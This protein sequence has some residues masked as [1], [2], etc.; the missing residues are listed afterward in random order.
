MYEIPYFSTLPKR[1]K[2]PLSSSFNEISDNKTS[3]ANS[4]NSDLKALDFEI[5]ENDDN[6]LDTYNTDSSV[7]PF[8]TSVDL[9]STNGFSTQKQEIAINNANDD[10]LQPDKSNEISPRTLISGYQFLLGRKV[11]KNIIQ[12]GTLL[13]PRDKTIDVD[14]V[15]L[16]RKFGKLVELTVSSIE[17]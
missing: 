13:I 4:T 11:V 1:A 8:A 9:T 7:Q 12:G 15:E 6:P 2:T 3:V 17:K 5:I 14:T 10:V 16:A